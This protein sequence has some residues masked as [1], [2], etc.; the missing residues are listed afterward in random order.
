M[1]SEDQP[2]PS[3][4]NSGCPALAN[5]NV[6]PSPP[7]APMRSALDSALTPRPSTTSVTQRPTSS[8]QES[9]P[10]GL[11]CVR[12][13]FSRYN[14]PEQVT[15][16]LMA[17]WRKGTQK[18]YATY[19]KKWM[20]FCR[21]RKIDCYSPPLSDTLQFLTDL[22]NQG[23]SYSTLNTARSALS[24]IVM[25]DGEKTFGSN[26]IV[27]RF[28]KGV[29]ESRKPKPKYDKIWDVSVVL[30]HLSSLYP[31]E[32]LS[33]KD[34]THKVLMLI[35][36]VS[37]QRGQSIHF[38]DLQYVTMEE[39]YYSF[40]LAEH[41]KTSTPRSPHTKIDISVYEPDSTICPLAC[42]KAYINKTKNLR[43][44]ETKL[45]ISYVRPHKPV[46][47]DTISRWTKETLRI[48]GIDTNVFTAHSTR[49][50]SVSKANEKD[51]P[52]HEIMANAGWKSAETFRKYYN[53]PVF[54]G[55]R[56]TP[57]ILGQ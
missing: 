22:F 37:S 56:L 53:K 45:F 11:S 48:C 17:S 30:K 15:D 4:G 31:N 19:I 16:I 12:E 50:A 54:Q 27:T 13:S 47:R 46:S 41:I 20:A 43:N 23:L 38:L 33:L 2:R 35:L 10:D 42:L 21:E 29:F 34:L 51:V 8:T 49:S 39:D 57:A 26:H 14:F 1:P 3:T 55:N 9:S 6:V 18:Q 28:M 7:T 44:S 32:S 40:D 24:T 25:I 36:L 52:I 5:P